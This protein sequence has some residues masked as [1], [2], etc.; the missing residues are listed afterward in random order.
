MKLL[1]DFLPIV[2]FFIVYKMNPETVAFISP[3]LSEDMATEIAEWPAMILATAFLIPATILQIAYTYMAEKKVEKMHLF[4]LAIVL[5]LG[6]ITIALKDGIF[7]LWK[8]TVVNWMFAVGFFA[9]QFIGEKTIIERMMG[10]S[11]KLPKEMWTK[12]NYAWIGFFVFS[13]LVN[14]YVAYNFSEDTWVNFKLFGMLGLTVVFIILQSIFLH[15]YIDEGNQNP[16][17]SDQQD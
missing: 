8:P 7:I 9:S 2:I 6:G 16:A 12:L 3:Y 10:A 13:G 15:K 14:L 4:T 17:N 1:V 11:I 5:V